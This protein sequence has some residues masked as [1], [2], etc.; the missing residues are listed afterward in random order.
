[1]SSIFGAVRGFYATLMFLLKEN[2]LNVKKT[3]KIKTD[4]IWWV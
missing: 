3:N 1:M 2:K 4:V